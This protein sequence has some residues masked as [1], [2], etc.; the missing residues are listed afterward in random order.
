MNHPIDAIARE[1]Y[2]NGACTFQEC[3]AI[4]GAVE[5]VGEYLKDAPSGE[6]S[7]QFIESYGTFSARAIAA[8]TMDQTA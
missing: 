8:L 6:L 4:I 7:R 2:R 1:L 3:S 5:T